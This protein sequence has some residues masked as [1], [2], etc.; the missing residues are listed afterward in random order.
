MCGE[1]S[2]TL[3]LVDIGNSRIKWAQ[4]EKGKLKIGR[5]F[6]THLPNLTDRL[7]RLW[8]DLPVP[9]C[10]VA[11]NV[12]G[13]VVRALMVD[14]IE[15]RWGLGIHFVVPQS[16]AHGLINAYEEPTA[17]GADRWVCLV[18]VRH[19]Y[20]L[21]ACIVD[22]GTAI[23]I[24][25]LDQSGRHLG[26]LIAPGLALMTRALANRAHGLRSVEGVYQG[27]LA[28]NTAAAML[29][30]SRHA[31]VGL[32][33]RALRGVGDLLACKPDLLLTG[34]DADTIAAELSVPFTLV[35]DLVLQGLLTLAEDIS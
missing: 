20:P 19:S 6:A 2:G 1:C 24:D 14:W 30:G 31:G 8:S 35:P 34:G 25:V 3:L 32:I 7:D 18:A 11:S 26:G 15:R 4:G 9:V 29:S 23:T 21:P 5:P 13:D 16:Q 10:V 17:L 22:C 28:R 33:E 12:G 27:M